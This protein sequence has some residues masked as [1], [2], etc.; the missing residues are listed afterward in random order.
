MKPHH[1]NIRFRPPR[2]DTREEAG[3]ARL[4][5]QF[6]RTYLRP[7]V[8]PLLF[9]AFWWTANAATPYL[10]AWYG[11]IV[12]DSI[13]WVTP[14]KLAA[15]GLSDGPSPLAQRNPGP[16]LRPKSGLARS[17][18][19]G[20]PAPGPQPDAAR[21]LF[22]LFG[23]YV[24][25]VVISNLLTRYETRVRVRI[26]R[27]LT[28]RLREDLHRKVLQLSLSYHRAHAPGRLMARIL[29][30]V[31]EVQ[32]QMVTTLQQVLSIIASIA[33]G[34][35]ILVSLNA[36]MALI[37]IGIMPLYMLLMHRTRLLRQ[38]IHAEIRHTNSWLYALATQKLDA[39]R[40]IQ[41]YGRERHETLNFHRLSS[42]YFRD[43]MSQQHIEAGLGG[44]ASLVSALATGAI[45]LFGTH[46]A[47]E[48]QMTLGSMMYTYAATT[49]LF[50][51]FQ[52]L[53]QLNMTFSKLLVVMQRLRQVLDEPG[54]AADPAD[55][56]NFPAPM[57][58]GITIRHLH[59]RYPKA[60]EPVLEDLLV[61]VPAGAWLCVMGSSGSGKTTLL[62]LL[63]R[64]LTPGGGEILYDQALLPK[65]RMH[66]LRKRLSLA[67]Q[68]P[69]IFSGTIRE[70]ICYG[71]P[72]ASPQQIIA[73]AKAAEIHDFIM[74]LPVHYETVLNEK[75]ANLSGGQRQRISLA[76]ALLTDP[77]VLL[78][79][80]CTSALDTETEQRI[81]NTLARI[82]QGRT[83]V[84]VSQRISMARRCQRIC[85][86]KNGMIEEY[87]SHDQL[88]AQNGYY[89]RLARQQIGTA[90]P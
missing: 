23:I 76:R 48:G 84:I 87:G 21:R 49:V 18:D 78:L 55:A 39:I 43:S 16:R 33:I 24:G 41:A 34:F 19:R 89:S 11:R 37:V 67:P 69:Q 54:D 36:R 52:Q 74:G 27:S 85:V 31:G 60:T 73:A 44:A 50:G 64:L 26:G 81:Q 53:T 5:L 32:D 15:S 12:V 13:L 66:S 17:L 14:A 22:V 29:S 8:R 62:Y 1:R 28:E 70:N 51:P 90:P 88:V 68:E 4:F 75:G 65:I 59:F 3:P 2:R 61:H 35:T 77:E 83:A 40:A 56:V 79:D 57:R 45:F 30:D 6:F 38:S 20:A 80:E 9:C 72:D 46:L 63:S 25:T 71:F 86:L 42:C 58:E 7:H 82:L 10:M 47:L